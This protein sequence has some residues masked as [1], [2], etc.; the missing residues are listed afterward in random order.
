MLGLGA[1]PEGGRR[2][3]RRV[4]GRGGGREGGRVGAF[5]IMTFEGDREDWEVS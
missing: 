3:L 4:R 5:C 1:G 2:M